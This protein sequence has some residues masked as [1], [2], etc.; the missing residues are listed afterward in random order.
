MANANTPYI[1]KQAAPLVNPTAAT[2]FTQTL[3][4]L[5]QIAANQTIQAAYVKYEAFAA[6]IGLG[7]QAGVTN[8]QNFTR[9]RVSAGGR[10]TGGGTTNFT[11]TIQFG[12]STIAASNTNIGGLTATAFNSASGNWVLDA[13]L[14]WDA[15]SGQINGTISGVAGSGGTQTILAPATITPITGQT[16]AVPATSVTGAYSTGDIQMFFSVAAL[17]SASF[18]GNLALLDF[19]QVEAL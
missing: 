19:F 5:A 17:F 8:N 2:V 11:P 12:R 10:V 14:L 3:N 16:L 15:T 1:A 4:P 13:S 9:F 6:G 7:S 18:A